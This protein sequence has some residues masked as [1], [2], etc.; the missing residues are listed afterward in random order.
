M[1]RLAPLVALVALLLLTPLALPAEDD[2]STVK[3]AVARSTLNQPGTHPFHLHAVL[4]PKRPSGDASQLSGEVEIWWVSQTQYRREVRSAD[5]HQIDIVNGDREWQQN[6]GDYFPE[7]L[8]EIAAALIE[9]VPDLDEVLKQMESADVKKL[10]GATHFSWM[11][12]SANG[13]VKGTMGAGLSIADSTGLLQYGS[14]FGWS[15]EFQDYKEFHGRMVARMVSAG[16]PEE[17]ARVTTL[18]DLGVVPPGFFDT[19]AT[20]GDSVLLKT[21]LIDEASLRKNLLPSQPPAWPPLQDG[22]LEGALTTEVVVDRSGKVRDV[23]TIVTNNPGVS[24]VARQAIGAMQ[25]QPY[26]LDGAP[27]QVVS[28]ITMSFKTVRPA[29]VEIFDT[30][31]AYF[32][33]GR[34]AGFPS[35]ASRSAYV[36]HAVFQARTSA[37]TVEQGQYA[38]T[39]ERDDEWRREASIGKSRCVRARHG[40]KYY[41]LAE[42]PDAALLQLAMK[43]LEPIP[44]IDTF[45][46]SD[47][48]IK[49]DAVDGTNTIRVLTGYEGPDGA[50]DPEH[51]RA[52][53]FDESGKLL[54][55]YYQGLETRS[56]DFEDFSGVSVARRVEVRHNGALGMLIRVTDLS[57]GGALPDNTF[58]LQGHEWKR[59]F[60]DEVR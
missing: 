21:A 18:E 49:R 60:T 17:V 54:K 53:W 25:F 12:E 8:R 47:W 3:K 48:K 13:D 4:S 35:A 22:P 11:I 9:P 16:S 41:R 33:R 34:H 39:W 46:E 15:G 20:G 31:R 42:G 45:V 55:T 36:M 14:G 5:F 37:G 19:G 2:V 44:A 7:W 26:L 27:V 56:L 1:Q 58:E 50:F 43:A 59:A 24:D 28:R 51:V 30:A 38:D 40:D 23:G 10:M 6:E 57:P 29:G 32:E 52:Y